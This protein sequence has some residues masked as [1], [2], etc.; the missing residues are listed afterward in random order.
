MDKNE[1]TTEKVLNFFEK[2]SDLSKRTA[3]NIHKG[4]KDLSK[5]I[6]EENQERKFKK[7]NPLFAEEFESDSFNIPNVIKIVDDADRRGIEICEGAIGWRE[8]INKIE[9]LCLYDEAVRMSGINFIPTAACNT[10]YCV[11]NYNRNNFISAD[12]IFSMAHNERLAELEHIA[13]SLGAKKYSIDI[14]ENNLQENSE[15]K[16][17]NTQINVK[18][19]GCSN[20]IDTGISSSNS[21]QM[22]GHFEGTFEEN[23][24][25]QYP[26]LK[27]FAY[28][29]HIKNLIEMRMSSSSSIKSRKI[30]LEGSS[31]ATMS[32]D[33]A[34]SV[35]FAMKKIGGKTRISMSKQASK[36]FYS[37]LIFNVEF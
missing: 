33:F 31:S 28:D 13:Y 18:S 1:K 36:E 34:A 21:N 32:Q 30:V 35:E 20:N 29:E 16:S 2:A 22:S 27:W 7:Y 19:V 9:V 12:K 26:R 23:N 14:V 37:N 10:F 17:T 24:T 25:L 5:K 6:K 3:D 8:R 4:A 11:D 15:R